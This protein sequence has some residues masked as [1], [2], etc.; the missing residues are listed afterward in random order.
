MEELDS[1]ILEVDGLAKFT[2]WMDSFC[3]SHNIIEYQDSEQYSEILH[4]LPE[5]ILSLT[6]DECFSHAITL[7]N[8]AGLLQKKL[9][10]I[11]SQYTWCVEAL[12]YLFSKQWSNYDKFLPAEIK[13]QSIVSENSYAQ[14]VEKS[15]LRLYAG[16]QILSETCRDI[17]KRVTLFQ[18]LGKSRS[19]R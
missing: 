19:F 13:K 9:D 15:R 6:S 8:Y 12:N 1:A 4:L 16:I 17:K 11:N 10:L 7:M 5:E 2:Q 18:D 3:I 14:S